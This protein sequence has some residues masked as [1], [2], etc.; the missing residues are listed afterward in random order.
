MTSLSEMLGQLG[1]LVLIDAIFLG[2]LFGL[3]AAPLAYGRRAAYAVLK[4]N[5]IGYFSNPTGYVF[6]CLFVVLT[7][8]GAFFDHR[9][10]STNLANLDQLNRVVPWI[11][12]VF[13]P[14]ITMSIWAEERRQGTDEL[15]L[16]LPA[17]DFD[18]VVG[19][20]LAAAGIFTVSL[21]FSQLSSYAVLVSLTLG[22][23]DS[24]LL[25]TTY[26]GYWFMGLA[27]LSLGM[28]ASFL[29]GNLTVGFIFGALF[30][31]PLVLAKSADTV[32]ARA[33]L[34]STVSRWSFASQF[35]DFGRG[36]ISLASSTYFILI[37]V[38]GIYL[39]IVL[40]SRRH[41]F[42]SSEG[43][44]W[45]RVLGYSLVSLVSAFVILAIL[46]YSGSNDSSLGGANDTY[47]RVGFSTIVAVLAGLAIGLTSVSLVSVLYGFVRPDWI[48]RNMFDQYV[49]RAMALVGLVFGVTYALANWDVVRLDMT[50]GQVSSLSPKTRELV[51]SLG[52]KYP[53]VID[54]YLS[55]DLPERYAKTRYNLLSLLKEFQSLA[56]QNIEVN[57][58]DNLDRAS[59]EARQAEAQYG[60]VPRSITTIARGAIRDENVILGLG[61]RCG[62]E[63]VSVPFLDYGV[64][65]EYE[66]VRSLTTVAKGEREHRR[67]VFIVATDAQMT[68][69]FTMAGM[70]PQQIPEQAIIAELKKQYVVESLDLTEPLSLEK[71]KK[72]DVMMV[73][74]PSSLNP[75]QMNNLV[76]AVKKGVPTA[77]FED[78]S[79]YYM[80]HVV[81]TAEPKRQQGMFGG[82][83]QPKGDIRMLWKALG[84]TAL[85]A[86]DAPAFG[87]PPVDIVWQR[88]QPYEQLKLQ[89]IGPE[90]VFI[91]K[92]Q[93]ASEE[94]KPAFNP[95]VPAVATL[96]EIL[97]PFPGGVIRAQDADGIE[98]TE[99]IRTGNRE[100]GR[101]SFRDLQDARMDPQ[102][103]EAKRGKPTGKQYVIA[104]AIRGKKGSESDTKTD[105]KS[106]ERESGDKSKSETDSKTKSE[107]AFVPGPV[108]AIYVADIDCIHSLFVQLRANPNNEMFGD[109]TFNFENVSFVLNAIDALAGDDRFV[110]IRTR[111]F[112]H[113][114]LRAVEVQTEAARSNMQQRISEFQGELKAKEG[115]IDSERDAAIKKV[116]DELE[117]LQGRAKKGES[118][119]YNRI[120]ALLQELALKENSL[121]QKSETNKKNLQRETQKKINE[122]QI[123]NEQEVQ[124]IQNSF[125]AWAILLPPVPPLLLGLVVFARRRVKEREGISKERMR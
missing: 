60:I 71:L 55:A 125:K 100:A 64:P 1:W 38:L 36:V 96:G 9:F 92:E 99:L 95:E 69:G 75:Q 65:V 118:V 2:L 42:N 28:V 103:L 74:Q 83:P 5:F 112:S 41:W 124:R 98:F 52:N 57:I 46:I 51:R 23:I 89:G 19:K 31:I 87:E 34:A 15:L 35:D 113:P 91:R 119:D 97:F 20:Y 48:R 26:L 122:I 30:N 104:A 114:T 117:K 106:A 109:V 94:A 7:S 43:Q 111:K 10:F 37:T 8:Y 90:F 110:E 68:G 120:S 62:L 4:R 24:G 63:K 44:S 33:N 18:I 11:M 49:V 81:G 25:F 121:R 59:E 93:P 6:L 56:G 12:L 54:A 67:K 70:Q 116:R 85:G 123:K 39:S 86:S 61:F 47:A 78:P 29:T 3:V 40:I 105:E 77:I 79:T 80:S 88:Y 58:Y 53:I 16:T 101:E 102:G 73:V 82:P 72:G 107:N 84:V 21:L 115:E 27:M 13:I 14:T 50:K 32:I 66:L 76:E 17:N 22:N 108:N 45:W